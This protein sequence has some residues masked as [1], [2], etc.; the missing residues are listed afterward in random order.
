MT[1]DNTAQATPSSDMND[2]LEYYK[3]L[4]TDHRD[5][6]KHILN[7]ALDAHVF[8]EAVRYD[9]FR[10]GYRG[11]VKSIDGQYF[12]FTLPEKGEFKIVKADTKN[13]EW[14]AGR[15]LKSCKLGCD[16]IKAEKS[17]E[18]AVKEDDDKEE[19]EKA[20]AGGGGT[21]TL[22]PASRPEEREVAT[23]QSQITEVHPG[24]TQASTPQQDG[25]SERWH[26]PD[27]ERALPEPENTDP[28]TTNDLMKAWGEQLQ[29]TA[30]RVVNIDP[31]VRQFM[32]DVL[33]KSA[34]DVDSGRIKL[35][36]THQTQ[37]NQWLTKSLRGRVSSL[38]NWLNKSRG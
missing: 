25:S 30:P 10:N 15:L 5:L 19:E 27:I 23:Q 35:S 21:A 7:M 38:S 22:P 1:T 8:P 32:I 3:S 26:G 9:E 6:E 36:S 13:K 20:G 11:A 31:K 34:E 16:L 18:H 33:H 17:V 28:W 4:T 12:Y 14:E 24:A 2:P 37:Y 29:A